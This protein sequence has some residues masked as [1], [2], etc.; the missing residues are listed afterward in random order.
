MSPRRNR[1]RGG[2]S[3]P[4]PYGG[5]RREGEEE[6]TPFG[7]WGRTESWR[8]EEW[9]VRPVGG[10]TAAKRYRC[11][12]C[13]QEIPQGQPHVVAWAQL[14]PVDDRRHWHRACWNARDRRTTRVQR[15][16][17]APRY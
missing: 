17:N 15:S 16:R 5:G 11:P 4:T 7:A 2:G 3:K 9:V 1:P 6:E 8:G 13:D 14:G 10:S 12:G